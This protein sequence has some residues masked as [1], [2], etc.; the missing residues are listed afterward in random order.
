MELNEAYKP[1]FERYGSLTE[2]AELR[3]GYHYLSR[4]DVVKS[5]EEV[6]A[7]DKNAAQIIAEC[8]T[9]IEQMT[10]YRQDLTLRYGELATMSSRTVVTLKRYRGYHSISYHINFTVIY[11]DGTEFETA[12]ENFS[13]KE[14]HKAIARFKELKKQHKNYGFVEDIAKGA[15]EK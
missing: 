6:A 3:Q 4:P 11:E 13:G 1:L 8:K 2:T 12:S 7:L 15:W 10:A 14:R 9:L 5:I